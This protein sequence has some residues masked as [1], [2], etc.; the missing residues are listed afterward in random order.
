MDSNP[1]FNE[2]PRRSRAAQQ[3]SMPRRLDILE[4]GLQMRIA[5]RQTGAGLA[6]IIAQLRRVRQAAAPRL[7]GDMLGR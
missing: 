1:V 4:K 5:D 7:L 3:R 2:V 6:Q